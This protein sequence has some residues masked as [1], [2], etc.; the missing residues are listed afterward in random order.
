MT[1]YIRAVLRGLRWIYAPANAPA[2]RRVLQD[3]PALALS[4]PLAARA[5]AAFVAPET[6]FGEHA[7]LD[8]RGLQ[9]VIEL[10]R[11]YGQPRG[12]LGSPASYL[13][14]RWHERARLSL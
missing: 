8:E 12:D 13:D 9:Q 14:T 10:R 11:A 6:G 4:E 1:R 5:L 2:A 3:E 7:S